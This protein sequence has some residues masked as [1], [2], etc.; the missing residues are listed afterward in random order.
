MDS[1][2]QIVLGAAIG[3]LVLGKKV[4]NRAVLW[5]AVAGTVPDLDVYAGYI[6]DDLTKNEMHRAFSHSLVFSLIAAPLFAW[7]VINIPRIFFL[8]FMALVLGVFGFSAMSATTWAVLA[9]I[10]AGVVYLTMRK[11]PAPPQASQRDWTKMMFWALFTH[12]LLDAHTS[13]GTQLLWPLPW[14]YSWNNIFVADPLYTIPLLIALIAVLTM[15]RESSRRRLVNGLGLIIS[16]LYMLWTLVAK[17]IAHRSFKASLVEQGLDY[18]DISSRPTPLNS[19]LWTANVDQGDAYLLGYYSLF[20]TQ[21]I[22][23]VKVN[24]DEHLLGEWRDHPNVERLWH[25]TAGEF[26]ITKKDGRLI[27]ND[28]RFGM[29]G[30]LREGGDFVFAYELIPDGDDLIV[31]LIEPPRPESSEEGQAMM[32]TL[33]NRIKGN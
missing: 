7:S 28:L 22:H 1:L 19:I 15:H 12:P 23:W 17:A 26:A 16:S 32:E 18:E 2:T 9:V 33:W 27:Y 30:D 29:M 24:K 11:K 21:D 10:Y 14:K 13:W 20:D 3:E 8:I 25:L 31:K 6:F 5:G 4:G